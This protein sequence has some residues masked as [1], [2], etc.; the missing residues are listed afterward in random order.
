MPVMVTLPDAGG[1][2]YAALIWATSIAQVL[3]LA[4]GLKTCITTVNALVLVLDTLGLAGQVPLNLA[5]K[6]VCETLEVFAV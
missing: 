3:T 4:L 1:V 2:E 5:Q 6:I